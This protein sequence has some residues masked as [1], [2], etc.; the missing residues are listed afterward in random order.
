MLDV[1]ITMVAHGDMM[2]KLISKRMKKNRFNSFKTK[3]ASV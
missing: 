1:G 3:L 2:T